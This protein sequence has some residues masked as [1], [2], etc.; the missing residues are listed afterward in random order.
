MRF[1]HLADLHLGKNVNG[2]SLIKD[3]EYAL[4]QIIKLLKKEKID[5]LL[6]AGDIY[7]R[8][9]KSVV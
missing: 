6:I 8:D 3:Q 1:M 9:R 7:Q 4:D 2:F 5:T